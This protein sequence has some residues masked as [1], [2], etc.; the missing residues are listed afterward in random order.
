[1]QNQAADSGECV[2]YETEGHLALI[3]IDR[4]QARNSV[5]PEVARGLEAAIDNVE[6]D[7][8]V[9]VAIVT[10]SPPV[11]CA[12]ADLKA[13]G[14]GRGAELATERGGFGGITRRQ[15]S[16]PLIAAVEG[17]ALAGGTE[18][19]LSCDL[20]VAAEDSR[21]GLP[22]VKRGIIAAGGGL[23]RLGA[24]IPLNVAMECAVTG[25]PIDAARAHAFGLVNDLCPSGEALDRARVL[26][27][28]IVANAPL[29][30]RESR[31]ILIECT[32][33]AEEAAWRRTA[34]V[35]EVVMASADMQEGV[36]AFI[37]KR[38]PSWSGR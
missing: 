16:K 18:I 2:R 10:G 33:A 25:D 3:T 36:A 1:M 31:S 34:E 6:A 28:R 17:A 21:F 13:I 8:D 24:R 15:R 23:F 11:F 29:A 32:G 22:E 20:V 7:D 37:E 9:W 38:A 14:A 19:V 26:A 5:N 30:V 4:P 12:G 35:N 27:G